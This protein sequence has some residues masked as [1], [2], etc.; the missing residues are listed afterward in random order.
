[1][2]LAAGILLALAISG[3][4]QA[5]SELRTDE[6]EAERESKL[7]QLTPDQPSSWERRF[8]WVQHNRWLNG[9][10]GGGD[11]LRLRLGGLA[12][13]QGFAVGPTYTRSDMWGGRVS[14]RASLRGSSRKAYLADFG[15]TLPRLAEGK[16]FLDL[17]TVSYNY[18]NMQFYGEG[19]CSSKDGRSV[20][21]LE[22]T[23]VAL[24]P[25]VRLIPGLTAGLI[26][27]Y[28]AINVGTGDNDALGHT[29]QIYTD[30][31]APGLVRQ[32][33]FLQG[34]G[35]VRY[36][37]R[38]EGEEPTSGG[39]Y[40]AE[41]SVFSD[42]DLGGH[43]FNKLDL[44]VQQYLPLFNRKR[45]FAVQGRTTLTAAHDGNT[46]PFYLQPVLGGAETLRGFRPFR[47]YDDNSLLLNG[48]YRFEAGSLLD[49]VLFADAGKVFHNWEQWNLHRLQ[50]DVG[51]GL[52]FKAQQRLALRI[53]TAFSHEGV[54]VWFRFR[55]VF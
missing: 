36:D 3:H 50:S 28:Q 21:R 35:F 42:R 19:P 33:N 5:Q 41:Y 46:V 44:A 30:A 53:D 37:W 16:A 49:I 34:G 14:V 45:V 25:G 39:L 38:S 17:Y 31:Q 48:E 29:E 55:N 52:R 9:L 11:G 2:R 13:A 12:Q 15:M 27:S 6:L 32:S 23:S 26:G 22:N 51:F 10:I 20:Y 18:P 47:F 24:N 8:M 7:L 54:Q 40:K 4:L 1:M 43:N